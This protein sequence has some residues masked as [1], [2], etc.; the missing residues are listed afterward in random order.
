MKDHFNAEIFFQLNQKKVSL[1][2]KHNI[3]HN[4]LPTIILFT[5]KGF[6][7]IQEGQLKP[8]I[9]RMPKG[10]VMLH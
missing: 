2:I 5:C 1:I 4:C 3:L 8:L 9:T 6:L 10:T 7:V